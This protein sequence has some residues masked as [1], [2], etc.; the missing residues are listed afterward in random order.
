M[1]PYP[2]MPRYALL[3]ILYNMSNLESEE[4][5][6]ALSL[7][8]WPWQ[9][10]FDA[11]WCLHSNMTCHD[12]SYPYRRILFSINHQSLIVRHRFGFTD[13]ICIDHQI[14]LVMVLSIVCFPLR[15]R[16]CDTFARNI[17]VKTPRSTPDVWTAVSTWT[18]YVFLLYLKPIGIVL[19]RL[20]RMII[21]FLRDV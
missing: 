12:T 18:C 15:S 8:M 1:H 6:G 7:T 10:C 5:F 21:C 9:P 11:L 2:T 4:L 20:F 13:Q 19:S 17:T 14:S 16:F 3:Y